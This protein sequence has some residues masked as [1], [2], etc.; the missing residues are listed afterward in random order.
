MFVPKQITVQLSETVDIS[1]IGVDPSA[2]CG[3]G[4][5]ASRGEYRIETSPD[6]TTWTL[7]NEGTFGVDD[8]GRLNLLTPGAG[9]QGVGFVRLTMLGNQTPDFATSCPDGAFSGCQFTD[10]TELE[11][12]GTPAS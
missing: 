10:L 8:R 4:G 3:D 6:G 7:A 9:T 5:S 2:T 1:Q 12:Y 11:V